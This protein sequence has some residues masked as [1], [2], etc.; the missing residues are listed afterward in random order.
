[1]PLC[2]TNLR[3]SCAADVN[4]HSKIVVCY[5]NGL[6]ANN[7]GNGTFLVENIDPMLCTNIIYAFADLNSVTHSI[8][9][10]YSGIDL[11]ENGGFGK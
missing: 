8:Q 2:G 4:S 3:S 9:S 5:V 7:P 1:M 6:A 10:R 11:E